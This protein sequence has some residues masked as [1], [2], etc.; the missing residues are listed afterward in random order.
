M[1]PDRLIAV[2]ATGTDIGKT[3][4]A[5]RLAE[6]ALNNGLRVAARKPAQSFDPRDTHPTDAEILAGVTGEQTDSVCPSHR[7]YPRA[8]A[9]PMAAHALGLPAFTL[10]ELVDEIAWPPATQLGI[11]E[12]AGGVHSPLADD[13]DTLALL[14]A[15]RPDL[16]IVV[17]DAQ[18]G[19]INSV[20]LTTGALRRHPFVVHVNRYDP[21]SELHRLNMRW[22][23][24]RDRLAVTSNL[25]DL[26]RIVDSQ[27]PQ[28][29]L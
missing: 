3:W 14:D 4:V 26:Y 16:V 19:T 1:R 5:A 11:V 18:L 22:L 28:A 25:D 24:E 7:W 2:T 12:G 20:R 23:A 27:V 29:H 10:D 6:I 15:I 13:G 21:D 9:P 8:I 17:A